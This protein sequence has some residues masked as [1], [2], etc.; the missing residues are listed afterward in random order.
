MMV[1]DDGGLVIGGV[2]F[3]FDGDKDDHLKLPHLTHSS[4]PP[5]PTPERALS[6]SLSI[7]LSLCVSSCFQ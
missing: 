6:L 7:S 2:V 1:V 3:S 4:Q 5:N